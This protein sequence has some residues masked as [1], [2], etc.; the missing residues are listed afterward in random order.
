MITLEH[1]RRVLY[2]WDKNQRV[3]LDGY[4]AG[5]SVHYSMKGCY[6]DK[7]PCVHAYELDDKVYADI[8]NM[9][10]VQAGKFYVYV[11]TCE[12]D[13]EGHTCEVMEVTVVA[14]P[15][16]DDYIYT[17]TE[18][19]KYETVLEIARMAKE[20]ADSVRA[21]A[22]NGAFNGEKGDK[23]DKGDSNTDDSVIGEYPWSSKKLVDTLCLPFE[24]A[25]AVVTCEPVENYP[26][27]IAVDENATTI[28]QCGKNL[29][30]LKS[31]VNIYNYIGSDGATRTHYGYEVRLPAGTYTAHAEPLVELDGEVYCWMYGY[32]INES[33]RKPVSSA[34]LVVGTQLRTSTFTLEENQIYLLIHGYAIPSISEEKAN[35]MFNDCFNVQIEMGNTATPYEAYSG[36]TF[37]IGETIAANSGVNYLFADSGNITVKGRE[38]PQATINKLTNAILALGGNV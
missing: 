16:P 17:E 1:G 18:I 25:G 11:Y 32:I 34:H 30:N 5:T 38:N 15:K 6:D 20:V 27:G 12:R 22:D 13:D 8:P 33:D 36:N 4:A 9:F 2:Q 24:K 31:G 14:R 21:D 7:A 37:A 28:T 10:L 23:G 35:K 29:W 19:F 3:I 26:L